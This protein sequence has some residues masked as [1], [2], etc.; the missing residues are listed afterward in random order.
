[1]EVVDKL[2]VQLLVPEDPEAQEVV[3]QILIQEAQAI[4]QQ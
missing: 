2:M 4:H 1:V 3:E